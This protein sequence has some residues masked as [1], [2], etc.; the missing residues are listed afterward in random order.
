MKPSKHAAAAVMIATPLLARADV[1]S[2]LQQATTWAA[3]IFGGVG[4]LAIIYAAVKKMW[5]DPEA[6]KRLGDVVVGGI[7][8][9]SASSFML[10]LRSWFS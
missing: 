3:V 1:A 4:V 7:I 5:G 8:G 9:L 10:L 6:N 2:G